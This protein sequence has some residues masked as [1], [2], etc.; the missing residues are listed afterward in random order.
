MITIARFFHVMQHLLWCCRFF[1]RIVSIHFFLPIIF[2]L[3][4]Q[5]LQVQAQSGIKFS[6]VTTKNGLSS[7]HATSTL[8]DRQGFLWIATENGLNRYDGYQT[9]KY[10]HDINSEYSLGANRIFS[11][12][13][14]SDGILWVGFEKKGVC[15]YVRDKDRF[16]RFNN[17]NAI[18]DMWEDDEKKLWMTGDHFLGFL[19]LKTNTFKNLGYQFPTI[20]FMEAHRAYHI[21]HH[22][23]IATGNDGLYL[24]DMKSQKIVK[25]YKTDKDKNSICSNELFNVYANSKD[26]VW[27]GSFQSGISCLDLTNNTFANY[28]HDPL[29]SNSLSG[30]SVTS[31][32]ERENNLWIGTQNGGPSVFHSQTGTF[33]NYMPDE[34]DPFSLGSFSIF[35]GDGIYADKQG[36][37]FVSTH[38]GRVSVFDPL[39]YVFDN[40][41]LGK[42]SANAI[43]KDKRNRLWIA[44]EKGLLKIVSGKTTFYT[45]FPMVTL[46]EDSKGRIWAG[47]FKNELYLFEEHSNS[48]KEVAVH[49]KNGKKMEAFAIQSMTL[50][51]DDKDLIIVTAAGQLIVLHLDQPRK[52]LFLSEQS[53]CESGR[54]RTVYHDIYSNKTKSEIWI[55]SSTG[56]VK[57]N[58]NDHTLSCHQFTYSD[59]SDVAS[60][61]V[62]YVFIESQ[63]RIW[64]KSQRGFQLGDSKTTQPT[65]PINKERFPMSSIMGILEQDKENLWISKSNG[66]TKFN[67]SNSSFVNYNEEDGL[68]GNEFRFRSYFKDSNGI[69]Y[70]GHLNGLTLFDPKN[71][72]ENPI[73]PTVHI[74]GL[75]LFNKF[76]AIGGADSLLKKNILSTNEITLSVNQSVITF[77]FA[78]IN[79]TK[80][81]KVQ[82]G[83]LLEGFEK[84]WNYVGSQRNATYTNLPPG[85]Y[86]FRVKASNS[87]GLWNEEGTSLIIHLLPPWWNTW[88]F[89]IIAILFIAVSIYAWNLLRTRAVRKRNQLLENLVRTRTIELE[90][91]KKQS[92][93][94][95]AAK[96]EFLAN[97]SHEI[98]TPLNGVIGFTDLLMKT[99]LN[100][101]QQQ[102][103]ATVSQSAHSLLD[104]LNDILDF[105]KIEAGKLDLSIEKT[106]LLEIGGMAADMIKYQAHQRGLEILLNISNEV[107]RY[108]WADE[109]RLRQILNNLLA[110]SVKFT[111]QGEIELKIEVLE[112]ESETDR[113]FRFS[114]RDTGI[115]IEPKNHEKIFEVFMQEDASVTKKFGGTGLGLTISNSLLALM[116]SQ[117]VLKSEVGKGSTFSFDVRFK[118]QDGKPMEWENIE[119]IKNVLVVDDNQNN[120]L[121]LKEMLALKEIDSIQASSGFEAIEAIKSGKIFDVVIMDYHMPQMDGIETIRAIRELI[122]LKEQPVIL[123]Y[124]SSD[125]EYINAICQE[126]EIRQRLVKPA[127]LNQLFNSLSRLIEK[128][129]VSDIQINEPGS[130]ANSSMKP[131][132]ILIA[133]DNTVNM[134]LV[135]SIF[136]NIVPNAKI[137]EAENGLLAVEKFKTER[138]DI[139]F[140]DVRMPERNGY[141]ATAAIRSLET[142]RRTPIIALTAGTAKGDRDKCLEAGMDDYISKPI[143]QDS[144]QKALRKWLSLDIASVEVE[145]LFSVATENISHFDKADMMQQLGNNQQVYK[146][147]LEASKASLDQCNTSLGQHLASLDFIGLTETAHKLKGVAL[148]SCFG[149]LAK[150]AG[151]LE[152]ADVSGNERVEQLVISISTEIQLVKELINLE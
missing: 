12:F 57:F 80:P 84:E 28:K 65:I 116:D 105:S 72:R 18:V 124:S 129:E 98:R 107:P 38:F 5:F 144:I 58:I 15:R 44:S 69:L 109:I 41:D 27:V 59:S 140:M 127:K 151:Q 85:T 52:Q 122:S 141:E 101:T 82:Y 63:K 143:V 71:F 19:D 136:E 133:E 8:V 9:Q 76:I 93:L 36:R 142:N 53:P 87:S 51:M 10:F 97:M 3:S 49:D 126:L 108:I 24:L 66:L 139:V 145:R 148:S 34:K 16:I 14:D 120:R 138:P 121:I 96:S 113:L 75:K 131:T 114:V 81:K 1:G 150:L 37:I 88:W 99:K 50:C 39:N 2:L 100:E 79:F 56:W 60:D 48:F 33:T 67:V 25:V 31:F 119:R 7:N 112:K 6:H 46:A 110:N 77:D 103:M 70:F 128:P 22:V 78:G 106:D 90:Q 123:L 152:E 23:W 92:E 130:D 147:L 73:A 111:E 13:E 17:K 43:L 132:T 102:Y 11:L 115:G 62:E 125:D 21:P 4:F 89:K 32:I 64:L 29:R 95:N 54:Q 149:E 86:T 137:I 55:S 146:R 61:Q 35:F 135:K 83:C 47:S 42:N 45:D 104:I 74:T 118:S 26:K 20:Y 68:S 94:A 30:N 91:S 134:L 40:I 117:L